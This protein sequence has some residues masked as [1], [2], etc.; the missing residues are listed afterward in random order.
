MLSERSKIVKGKEWDQRSSGSSVVRFVGELLQTPELMKF[1]IRQQNHN[2]WNEIFQHKKGHSVVS[3]RFPHR[4]VWGVR[5]SLARRR[6]SSSFFFVQMVMDRAPLE[7]ADEKIWQSFEN[8]KEVVNNQWYWQIVGDYWWWRKSTASSWKKQS[9]LPSRTHRRGALK[10]VYL[11]TC[12][13][14]LYFGQYLDF[15]IR[16][17]GSSSPQ[18][19]DSS[20]NIH[21]HVF[22]PPYFQVP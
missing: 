18:S 6:A 8:L 1:R 4:P 11:Y 12:N 3:Y 19:S 14:Q 7:A 10:Q 16:G 20:R 22:S 17:W 13:L 9:L 21:G 15:H 5:R 2:N